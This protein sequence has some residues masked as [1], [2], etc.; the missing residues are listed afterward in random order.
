MKIAGIGSLKDWRFQLV[1]RS[2]AVSLNEFSFSPPRP[3][4]RYD[5]RS[6]K[7]EFG[8]ERL[9][10][11]KASSVVMYYVKAFEYTENLFNFAKIIPTKPI[12]ALNKSAP[13]IVSRFI[14]FKGSTLPQ[15]PGEKSPSTSTA[16]KWMLNL[17]CHCVE[18]KSFTN[19]RRAIFRNN[20]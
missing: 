16:I 13:Q 19:A 1:P 7:V 3:S 9:E 10:S 15:G 18:W 17:G 14:P 2:F 20:L 11:I 8:K 6:R 5:N 4:N 12:S